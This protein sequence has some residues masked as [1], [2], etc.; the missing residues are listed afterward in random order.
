MT[1]LEIG[2]VA[3]IIGLMIIIVIHDFTIDKILKEISE[4]KKEVNK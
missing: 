3:F 1:P 4:L 2:I